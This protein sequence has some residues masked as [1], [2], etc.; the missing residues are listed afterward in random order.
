MK[1][2]C[3]FVTTFFLE[4]ENAFFAFGHCDRQFCVHFY[5]CILWYFWRVHFVTVCFLCVFCSGQ[6]RAIS[7]CDSFLRFHCSRV[8]R[9]EKPAE[10]VCFSRGRNVFAPVETSVER[11]RHCRARVLLDSA[12]FLETL[13]P[14]KRFLWGCHCLALLSLL[15]SW[16][17]TSSL[18]SQLF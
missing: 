8:H 6:S 2:T 16:Q 13:Q 4:P 7:V 9:K 17:K 12:V 1:N 5:V 11:R 15:D 14:F 18:V 3:F 10:C